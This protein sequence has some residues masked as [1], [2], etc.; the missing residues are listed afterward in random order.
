MIISVP[1]NIAPEAEG[2][3]Y[4]LHEQGYREFY[5]DGRGTLS[6][7]SF[8]GGEAFYCVG[9]A[10]YRVGEQRYLVL[11]HG[12]EYSITIEPAA[13]V[14]SFCIFFEEGLAEQIQH[15]LRTPASRLLEDPIRTPSQPVTFYERT[16]AHDALLSPV[17]FEIRSAIHARIAEPGWLCE[18]LHQL[19]Q[20]LFHVHY[21]LYHEVEQM[22]AVRPATRAELYRR[23]HQARD[24]AHAMFDTPLTL[25]ELAH[26]ACLSPNHLLRTFRQAFG[27][28]PH[29]YIT[30]RRLAH[31]Q[32]LLRDTTLPITEICA[33]VGF[34]S[35][36]A[37]SWLFR[38]HIGI[39]PS[40][41]RQE[42][43]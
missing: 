40:I 6:I 26:V 14:E 21:A 2:Q 8:Y 4:I 22:P 9:N 1:T 23:L 11:N 16:Y 36:G 13:P 42:T 5:G 35:L 39:S 17:L 25:H 19:M 43:R 41:Y 32:K 7:K 28:T 30:A 3:S 18:R 38:R 31:A 37:F 15:S 12:T 27:Q 29:Q 10:R 24:Y 20:S 33:A 34:E